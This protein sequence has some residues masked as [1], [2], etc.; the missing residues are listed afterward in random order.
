MRVISKQ[1]LGFTLSDG[2]L[3]VLPRNEK[4]EIPSEIEKDPYF[5]SALKADLISILSDKSS[6]KKKKKED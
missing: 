2:S 1:A 5:E 6:D 3:F 4:K